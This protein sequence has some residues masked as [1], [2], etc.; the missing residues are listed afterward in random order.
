MCF[1]ELSILLNIEY[2]NPENK[3]DIEISNRL[4]AKH[5]II[6]PSRQTDL[7]LQG[8][9]LDNYWSIKFNSTYLN[10]YSKKQYFFKSLL[11]NI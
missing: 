2:L 1:V 6:S 11:K 3:K 4:Q 10:I 5:V 9:H 7:L 8:T